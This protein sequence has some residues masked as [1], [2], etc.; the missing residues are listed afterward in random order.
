MNQNASNL[1][2]QFSLNCT[3]VLHDLKCLQKLIKGNGDWGNNKCNVSVLWPQAV[4]LHRNVLLSR[5]ANPS[6][7]NSAHG[8][9][10]A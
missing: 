2:F 10:V 7:E 1:Y 5:F 4:A 8:Y 6:R 9:E 3:N